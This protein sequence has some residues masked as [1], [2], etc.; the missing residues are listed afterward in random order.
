MNEKQEP[1]LPTRQSLLERLKDWDDQESW[2][3]F[4]D[5]YWKLIYGVG[6]R[7]GLS[8][9]DA[10][11][12]V[13]DTV[14]SVAR[15]MPTFEYEPNRCAFKTWLMQMTRW[16]LA[17]RFGGKARRH[18]HPPPESLDEN[19]ELLAHASKKEIPAVEAIWEEEWQK[20]LM[21]LAIRAVKNQVPAEHFQ[22]FD[23]Y[24]L[25]NWP[26]AR[27]ARSLSV[28]IGQ[29]YLTKHRVTRLIHKE[30]RRLEAQGYA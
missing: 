24:V 19:P 28:N 4:Y 16:R 9:S 15:K 27:V 6:K 17:D 22:I 1:F 23:L 2:K 14:I 25:R 13:Q 29:V 11:D 8:H 12:L 18:A 20:N 5:T 3:Q 7:C 26:A 21:D 30:I 10:E